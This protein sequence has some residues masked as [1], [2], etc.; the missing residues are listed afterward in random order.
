MLYVTSLEYGCCDIHLCCT[1]T[2]KL[3]VLL[4]RLESFSSQYLSNSFFIFLFFMKAMGI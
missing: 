2:E 4:K 1:H 3:V